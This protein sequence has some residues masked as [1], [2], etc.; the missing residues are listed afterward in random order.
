ME[1]AEVDQ[2]LDK[3][4]KSLVKKYNVPGFRKGKTPRPILEQYIGKPALLEEA[5]EIMAP[6]AYDKAVKELELKPIARPEVK[7]DKSDPVVY[8]MVVPL[9]P[10]IKLGLPSGQND[11]GKCTIKR[12]DYQQRHRADPPPA[13]RL[14]AGGETGQFQRHG[15]PGYREQ[16]GKPAFIN[17]KTLNSRLSRNRNIR[18]RLRRGVIGLKKGE[19]KESSSACRRLSKSGAA[20][21]EVAFKVNIKEIK[22]EKLPEMNDDL[23]KTVNAEFKRSTT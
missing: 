7:L 19:S 6:E 15:H 22:Q 14:G 4:Y 13:F 5:I 23:A 16:R 11:P 8:K 20:G 18:S 17:Q 3:A 2:G 9:E 21:K 12:R 1:P 10:V